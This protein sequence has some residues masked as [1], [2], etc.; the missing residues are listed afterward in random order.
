MI[1]QNAASDKPDAARIISE[2]TQTRIKLTKNWSIQKLGEG[3]PMRPRW[4]LC[5]MG[6]QWHVISEFMP[7]GKGGSP[8]LDDDLRAFAAEVV[9]QPATPAEQDKSR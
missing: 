5:Y 7:P 1:E 3:D 8:T 6:M 2:N 9:A 4:A